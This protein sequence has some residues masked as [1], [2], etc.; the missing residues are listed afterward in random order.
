MEKQKRIFPYQIH[1]ILGLIWFLIGIAFYS[2][3]ESVIWIAGGIVMIVI[4]FFN[5]KN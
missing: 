4:G 1:I 3:I 5:R 2:G